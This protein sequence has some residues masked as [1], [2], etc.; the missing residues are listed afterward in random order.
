M[1][2]IAQLKLIAYAAAALVLAAVLW[3]AWGYFTDWIREPV[4]IELA[5][6]RQDL[7][8]C[9]RDKGELKA[10]LARQ[11]EAVARL[12]AEAQAAADRAAKAVLEARARAEANFRRADELLNARPLD[13]DPCVSASKRGRAYL[14]ERRR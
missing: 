14:E 6:A 7:A 10:A 2:T 5:K 1:P 13:A 3:A 11:N 8:G 9:S 4:R 12:E